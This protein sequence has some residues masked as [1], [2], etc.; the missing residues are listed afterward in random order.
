VLVILIYPVYLLIRSSTY[1]RERW[2]DSNYSPYHK[3][4]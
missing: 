4:S 1:E 3:A 2:S